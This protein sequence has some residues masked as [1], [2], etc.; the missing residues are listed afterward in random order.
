MD[1]GL[2]LAQSYRYLK[3]PTS[4]QI[5]GDTSG[6][7]CKNDQILRPKDNEIYIW[8]Y[9]SDIETKLQMFFR[10]LLLQICL[11]RKVEKNGFIDL[12]SDDDW[13]SFSFL[14]FICWVFVDK[15]TETAP[16]F[17]GKK[18]T[19]LNPVTRMLARFIN[20]WFCPIC[21]GCLFYC[22]V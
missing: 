7:L 2:N 8:T 15:T 4:R 6:L 22:S 17:L 20:F 13:G 5:F 3:H 16:F 18:N 12:A 11:I 1:L 19:S 10:E 21:G 9:A 14:K